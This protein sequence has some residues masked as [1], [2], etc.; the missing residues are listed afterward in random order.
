MSQRVTPQEVT[1]AL[2]QQRGL[3]GNRTEKHFR[4]FEPN[5]H[6][7][8]DQHPSAR[9]NEDKGTWVC[10]VCRAGGG[11]LSAAR[12][13]GLIEGHESPPQ[14]AT[15]G[16]N[17]AQL[18]G[19]RGIELSTLLALGWKDQRSPHTGH[20][21]VCI[22]YYTADGEIHRWRWRLS[23]ND[24]PLSKRFAWD[25]ETQAGLIPYGLERLKFPNNPP[26]T[27]Q[28]SMVLLVEGETDAA[29]AHEHGIP[30][31]GIPGASTWKAEWIDH[32]WHPDY[33][34]IYVWQEPGPAGLQ[35]V[36]RIGTSVGVLVIAAPAH[37]KDLA[38][39]HQ[40]E[41]EQ[42]L[43]EFQQLKADAVPYL[44]EIQ[45][46]L[47]LSTALNVSPHYHVDFRNTGRRNGY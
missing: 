15:R 21:A 29:V 17:L 37:A 23:L 18:A 40:M 38:Q 7:N 9:W 22:P 19:A 26:E 1:A 11:T 24:G 25:G 28:R 43:P 31:I 6:A 10:D 13:L 3:I 47:A 45:P 46:E 39:L 5:R 41:G 14:P 20:P 27:D 44:S 4:C 33:L 35:F 30:C 42:F 12:A 16:I 36:Q 32:L 8:G 34:N 2:L